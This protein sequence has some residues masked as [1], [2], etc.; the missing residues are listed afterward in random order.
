MKNQPSLEDFEAEL[1]K[2]MAVETSIN[3]ITSTHNIGSLQLDT[4]PLKAALKLEATS[5]K[6]QFASN[7]HKQ[8]AEDLKSF[9][10]YIR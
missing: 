6:N 8:G 4:T 1:K 10:N 7:L 5:W 2:Y 3:Q 9:D